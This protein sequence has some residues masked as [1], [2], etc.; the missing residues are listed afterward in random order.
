MIAKFV[1]SSLVVLQDFKSIAMHTVATMKGLTR[2]FFRAYLEIS[3]ILQ[4]DF[5]EKRFVAASKLRRHERIHSP[6]RKKDWKCL[7]CGNSFYEKGDLRRHMKQRCAV[8]K[9]D[10]NHQ[11]RFRV[12]SAKFHCWNFSEN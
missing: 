4:C 5:C 1:E 11:A 7:E 3:E 9:M 2:F 6:N 12:Y 8:R 10:Q